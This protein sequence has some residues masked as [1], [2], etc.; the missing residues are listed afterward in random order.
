MMRSEELEDISVFMED[1]AE[2]IEKWIQEKASLS[3]INR[4]QEAIN[5]AKCKP[6][7]RKSITSDLIQQWFLNSPNKDRVYVAYYKSL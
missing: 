3:T 5:L 7:H 1:K 4:I 6:S 2:E